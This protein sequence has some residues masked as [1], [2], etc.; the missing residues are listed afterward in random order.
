MRQHWYEVWVDESPG[1]PYLLI[2]HA[3]RTGFRILDPQEGCRVVLETSDLD[4]ARTFL[5]EDEYTL[6]DGRMYQDEG[7]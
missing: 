6:V 5:M 3:T 1:L 7:Y 4:K 2:L